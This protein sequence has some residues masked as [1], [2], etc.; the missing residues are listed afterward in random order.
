M[1]RTDGDL[2]LPA[3]ERLYR[4]PQW[5]SQISAAGII[6]TLLQADLSELED[7]MLIVAQ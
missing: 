3:A 7:E 5:M 1:L 2:P 6:N 4:W